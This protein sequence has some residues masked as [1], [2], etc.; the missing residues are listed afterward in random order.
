[1]NK[2][3]LVGN[4]GGN[5]CLRNFENKKMASFSLA[6]HADKI[7][8][9][10]SSKYTEWHNVVAWGSLAEVC[11][12]LIKKGKRLSV[13][14]RIKTRQYLDHFNRRVYVTEIVA[15]HIEEHQKDKS[16]KGFFLD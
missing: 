1:M 12:S 3:K 7:N 8:S 10:K 5:L 9:V 16:E 6:T 13:E 14:G 4:V 15:Q 2:V 11:E